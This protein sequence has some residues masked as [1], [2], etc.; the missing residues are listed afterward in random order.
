MIWRSDAACIGHDVAIFYP[1]RTAPTEPALAI[2]ARCPVRA[3][4]L[5]AADAAAYAY[6]GRVEQTERIID[7]FRALTGHD[8]TAPDPTVTAQAI[9]RMLQVTA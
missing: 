6:A 7:R 4:C 5:D 3:E 8:T 2:C 1:D 9:T